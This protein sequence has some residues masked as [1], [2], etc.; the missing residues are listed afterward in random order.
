MQGPFPSTAG[1]SQRSSN[2][3][4]VASNS[5]QV[6]VRF[7]LS[8]GGTPGPSGNYGWALDDIRVWIP[9]NQEASITGL[10]FPYA[11]PSGCGL[12]N[13]TIQILIANNGSAIISGGMTA[14]FQRNNGTITT[15]AV[16]Q[17]IIPGDTGLFTFATAIDLSSTVDTNYLVRA[18]ISLTNDPTH[19]NDTISDSIES[20]VALAD[21]TIN[22]TSI[23]Y[24][25]SV[26]LHAVHTDSIAWFSDPLAMNMLQF[27]AYYTTPILYDTTAYYCQALGALPDIKITEIVQ[28][29]TGTGYTNPYPSW[30]TGVTAGDYDGF[31]ITNLGNGPADL[32]GYT[33]NFYSTDAIMGSERIMDLSDRHDITFR[34]DLYY[35]YKDG[36]NVKQSYIFL[37]LLRNY[38]RKST[39]QC[40]PG[41]LYKRCTG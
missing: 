25:T 2:I 34:R 36:F 18:W 30:M 10:M 27:G 14:S 17:T 20:R 3:S 38:H 40:Y 39:I 33:M 1:G 24:G 6:K 29:E 19:S 11:L 32:S 28:F 4:S 31:E 37:L 9:S 5:A 7:K 41:I 23:L 22:D 16:N 13:E 21:P 15:Q 8:D 35:R 12:S 26:T